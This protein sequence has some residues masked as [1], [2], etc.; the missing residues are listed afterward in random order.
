MGIARW[1]RAVLD[2]GLLAGD[3]FG[4]LDHLVQCG[5][6]GSS[7]VELGIS[8]LRI[9]QSQQEGRYNIRYVDPGA[10]GIALSEFSDGLSIDNIL[11][12]D[13]RDHVWSSTRTVGGKDS[14][15]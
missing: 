3:F 7:S 2:Q 13:A 5:R 9:L 14:N 8:V 1:H 4:A 6:V 11:D 12:E 10:G 15:Q